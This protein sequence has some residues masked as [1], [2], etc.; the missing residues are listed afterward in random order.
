[1]REETKVECDRLLVAARAEAEKIVD[2]AKKKHWEYSS[3]IEAI[4][5]EYG[6]NDSNNR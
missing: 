2:E 1:M 6:Q 4:L 3:A 5:K